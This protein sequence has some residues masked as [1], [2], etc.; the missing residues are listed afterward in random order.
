MIRTRPYGAG[1]LRIGTNFEF[2]EDIYALCF[3]VYAAD[4]LLDSKIDVING[5]WLSSG[6]SEHNSSINSN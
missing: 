2:S 1:D 5:K 3:C 6:H 4:Y